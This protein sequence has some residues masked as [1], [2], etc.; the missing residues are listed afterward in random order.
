[1]KKARVSLAAVLLSFC[2]GGKAV[3]GLADDGS[4]AFQRGDYA[5][6]ARLW[7]ALAKKGDAD[8]QYQLGTLY[9]LGQGVQQ[10]WAEAAEWYHKAAEQGVRLAQHDLGLMYDQGLGVAQNYVEAVKWYRKGCRAGRC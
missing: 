9:R 8:G 1:M 2:L 3:L 5:T 10:D 7:L 4:S 6:A